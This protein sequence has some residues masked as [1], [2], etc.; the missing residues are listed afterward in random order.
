MRKLGENVVLGIGIDI[1][2]IARVERAIERRRKLLERLFTPPEI[3]YCLGRGRPGAS[4]AVRFAAKEAVR[5]ACSSA[6]PDEVMPWLDVEID[7]DKGHPM[8]NFLGNTAQLA[9]E[10]GIRDVFVSLSHSKEYA[11]AAVVLS[12]DQS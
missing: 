10:N 8:V 9:A 3:A 7:M 2:E 6:I 1:I 4:L 11:C 12:G 5:K